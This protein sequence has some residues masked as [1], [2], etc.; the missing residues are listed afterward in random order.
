ME[1]ER[2]EQI[3]ELERRKKIR[4]TKKVAG[5][6]Q[7]GKSLNSKNVKLQIDRALQ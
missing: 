3:K 4:Q 1:R 5:I 7:L 2:A 6:K